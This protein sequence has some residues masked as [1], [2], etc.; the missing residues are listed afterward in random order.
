MKWLLWSALVVLNSWKVSI[1]KRT[2]IW[3]VAEIVWGVNLVNSALSRIASVIS[4]LKAVINWASSGVGLNPSWSLLIVALEDERLRLRSGREFERLRW[5][6]RVRERS[7]RIRRGMLFPPLF[8]LWLLFSRWIFFDLYE[9]AV[10][11]LLDSTTG[12]GIRGFLLDERSWQ[13]VLL[14]GI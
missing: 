2:R 10:D 5:I 6:D 7:R 13:V 8:L 12:G 11:G 1:P 9:L 14:K 3:A 4:L